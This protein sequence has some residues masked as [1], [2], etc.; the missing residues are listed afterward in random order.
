[1]EST[2]SKIPLLHLDCVFGSSGV[3][4]SD[5]NLVP[6]LAKGS[7]QHPGA[8]LLGLGIKFV[9]L[10]NKSHPLMQDLPNHTAEAMGHGPDGGLAA[11][12]G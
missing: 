8:L 6:E 1:M 4:G 9:A 5:C 2:P 3:Y 10:L 11:E 7:R 12:T